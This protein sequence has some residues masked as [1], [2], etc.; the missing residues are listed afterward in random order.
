MAV[1][2]VRSKNVVWDEIDGEAVLVSTSEQ[3]TWVL[4]ATAS[5]IWKCCDGTISIEA[6]ARRIASECGRE[7]SRVK[8]ELASFC[9]EMEQRGLLMG[10]RASGAVYGESVPGSFCFKGFSLPPLIKM[11]SLSLGIRGRPSPRSV[12]GQQ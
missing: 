12:S 1:Q 7:A 2:W 6:L 10:G 4:N 9:R 3:K 5:I 8:A 11:E